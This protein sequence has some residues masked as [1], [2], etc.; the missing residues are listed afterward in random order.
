[1]RQ[2][3]LEL[4]LA[5]EGKCVGKEYVSQMELNLEAKDAV[6]DSATN[7]HVLS[8][9]LGMRPMLVA[10]PEGRRVS[11]SEAKGMILAL[12]EKKDVGKRVPEAKTEAITNVTILE[13]SEFEKSRF[14]FV[15]LD[16]SAAKK[17]AKSNNV[18]I[19][20]VDGSLRTA[21]S[22]E[23]KSATRKSGIRTF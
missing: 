13:K 18:I 19:R 22:D 21:T 3:S 6:D 14:K 2:K 1:M 8:E 20:D 4:E 11:F 10:V 15:F 16:T 23:A 17:D 12:K 5:K 9:N 7:R